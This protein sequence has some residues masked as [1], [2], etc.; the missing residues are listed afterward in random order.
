MTSATFLR[1]T[2]N[3]MRNNFGLIAKV[4]S[5]PFSIDLKQI[6]LGL[7]GRWEWHSKQEWNSKTEI[8]FRSSN[9]TVYSVNVDVRF[10][11]NRW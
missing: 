1:S 6:N 3:L 11:L 9:N 10:G 7:D 8:L 5:K 2:I 4:N